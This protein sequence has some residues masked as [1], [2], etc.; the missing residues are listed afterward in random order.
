MTLVDVT[1]KIPILSSIL[2]LRFPLLCGTH[3]HLHTVFM[4]LMRD[5]DKC[6]FFFTWC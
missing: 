4:T 5:D 3:H 6:L 2:F 1:V